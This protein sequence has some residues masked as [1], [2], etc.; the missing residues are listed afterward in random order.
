MPEKSDDDCEDPDQLHRK[1]VFAGLTS[2]LYAPPM[3][4]IL[5]EVYP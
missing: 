4:H 2:T 5:R 3:M 1:N